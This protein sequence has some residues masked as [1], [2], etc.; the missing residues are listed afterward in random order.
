A[1]IVRGA[2]ALMIFAASA[3]AVVVYLLFWLLTYPLRWLFGSGGD[4]GPSAP[5]IAPPALP[6]VQPGDGSLV[7]LVKSLLFWLI[8]AGVVAY[9]LSALWRQ[10]RIQALV[11]TWLG[12]LGMRVVAL[13]AA[14]GA[15][16]ARLA[17]RAAG[18]AL[19]VGRR[20]A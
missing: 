16:L 5:P 18:Q 12:T 19:E 2:F 15:L 10:G 17:R 3:L 14:L 4:E 8:A 1:D 6:P 13:L 7:G 20:L 11:P 9:A